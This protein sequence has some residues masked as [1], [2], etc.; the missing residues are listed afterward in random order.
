[1][2][3]IE[4]LM[5]ATAYTAQPFER[6]WFIENNDHYLTILPK[7]EQSGRFMH[8]ALAPRTV[9]LQHAL[10]LLLH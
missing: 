5:N 4:C 10:K 6:P 2:S 8:L 7:Q 1:M 9:G 3:I